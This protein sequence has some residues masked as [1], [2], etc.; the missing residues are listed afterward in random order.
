MYSYHGIV[1]DLLKEFP[2]I[3]ENYEEEI[4]FQMGFIMQMQF[5][6]QKSAPCIMIMR[7]SK[8]FMTNSKRYLGKEL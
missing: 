4:F 1:N 3:S 7:R 2:E 5:F 8:G 6:Q